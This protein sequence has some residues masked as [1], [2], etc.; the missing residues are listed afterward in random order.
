MRPGGVECDLYDRLAKL[1][2]FNPDDDRSPLHREVGRLRE[3]IHQA[4]AILFST[5]EYAGA[6]PGSFKNLL[7]WTIGDDGPGSIHEKPVG[8][9]NTSSRGAQGAYGELRTVLGYAQA[10]I[11]DAA[12]VQIPI[13]PDM[14]TSE[15]L[16]EHQ[17]ACAALADVLEVLRTAEQPNL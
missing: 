15:G 13:T 17:A 14:V 12:C 1:P 11:I 10:R 3:S 9:V 16:V 2:A 5:P 6:L 7:D 4:G 8:W